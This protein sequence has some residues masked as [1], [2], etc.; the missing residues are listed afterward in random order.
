MQQHTVAHSM[1]LQDD[2]FRARQHE[3]YVEQ[4][5]RRGIGFDLLTGG[6]AARVAHVERALMVPHA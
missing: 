6:L 4:L 1:Q 5:T 3:W 2:A